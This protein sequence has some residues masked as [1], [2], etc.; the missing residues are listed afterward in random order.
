MDGYYT[1][2]DA[3][4]RTDRSGHKITVGAG[5]WYVFN[6]VPGAV[7]VA[8]AKS[9]NDAE[10]WIN[11]SDN[12]DNANKNT[13]TNE[14]LDPV[15]PSKT[16]TVHGYY[17]NVQEENNFKRV[18][19]ATPMKMPP[20]TTCYIINLVTGTKIEFHLPES[21]SDSLSANFDAID[22][23]GRT[24]ALQGYNN[25]GPR[26]LSFDF[27]LHR[28]FCEFGVVAAVSQLK[29]LVYPAYVGYIDAPKAFVH[30]GNAIRG[31]FVVN[32]VSV[33]YNIPFMDDM[34]VSANVSISITEAGDAVYSAAQIEEGYG[35]IKA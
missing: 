17:S 20:N 21:V 28:D 29:A 9:D 1:S 24:N 34:Y 3:I 8:R 15:N 18:N 2:R 10:A 7:A 19:S 26:T 33:T 31:L 11:E 13:T 22:I 32:D 30:L 6:Y 35:M 25:S 5:E 4:D 12:N 23:R 14:A 27:D 16:D